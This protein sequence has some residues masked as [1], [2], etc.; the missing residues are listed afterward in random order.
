MTETTIFSRREFYHYIWSTPLAVQTRDYGLTEIRLAELCAK[1]QVPCPPHGY[2][3]RRPAEATRPQ[4]DPFAPLEGEQVSGE[5]T[6]K[7]THRFGMPLG[8][9]APQSADRGD[10]TTAADPRTN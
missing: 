10:F 3:K 7:K 2:W 9:R 8:R 5:I 4:I 6:L 1:H